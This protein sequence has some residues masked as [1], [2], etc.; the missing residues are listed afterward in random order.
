MKIYSMWTVAILLACAL[1]VAAQQTA[2]RKADEA[3]IAKLTA[4]YQAAYSRHDAKA[5][6]ALYATDGDRRTADGRVIKGRAA[7]EKQLAEDFGGRFKAAVVKFDPA[8]D[9]RFLNATMAV[10]DGLAQLSGV[11]SAGGQTVPSARYFHTIVLV[12]RNGAWQILALRN[13][14]APTP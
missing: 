2:D 3:A 5:A 11:T 4:D 6:A 14:Q 8:E 7:V 13:W 12:K 1:P 10:M 9:I